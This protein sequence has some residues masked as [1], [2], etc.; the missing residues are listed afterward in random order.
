MSLSPL[1]D[2]PI[3]QFAEPMRYVGTSDRNF[4]DRYYF[5]GYE[6]TGE[7][8]FIAGLGVYPNLGVTDA[9]LCVMHE[10]QYRVVRASQ[11]LGCRPA[12]PSVG[13]FSVEVVEALQAPPR[14]RSS[15]TSGASPTT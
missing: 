11:E 9:F 4:Y 7:L 12:G 15:P 14:P 2:Y 1:D 5:I 13:P 10:G 6:K 8:F 3:H